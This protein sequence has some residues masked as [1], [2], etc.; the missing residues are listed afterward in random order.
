M[1]SLT[2][3]KDEEKLLKSFFVASI[4]I[5]LSGQV[6][7]A[8]RLGMLSTEDIPKI[9]V[10]VA[11]SLPKLE[12]TGLDVK[13]DLFVTND[14]RLYQGKKTIEFKCAGV[15]ALRKQKGS[16]VLLAAL[17]SE[18]GLLTLGRERYQG[19]LLLLGNPKNESCDVVNEIPME[20]YI[21]PLLAKEMHGGWPVEALKAQAV[22]A[23]SYALD[24]IQSQEASRTVGHNTFYDLESSEKHQVGGTFFDITEN[25]L[26]AARSTKG[27]VL[28]TKT[29]HKLT[30]IFFHSECGGDTFLPDQIWG[31]KIE[32]YQSVACPDEMQRKDNIWKVQIPADTFRKFLN[33]VSE[34]KFKI[35]FDALEDAN[36]EF[37]FAP[38]KL[39]FLKVR[40]YFGENVLVVGKMDFKRFF[41][42]ITFPS[43]HFMLKNE[44]GRVFALGRGLG[45]GVGMS[46]I[47][48][49]YLAEKGW[50]YRQILEYYYP[51]HMIKKI[52]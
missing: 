20:S 25:T 41:G 35:P 31:N 51:G 7:A 48:A 29:T 3:F 30:P 9:R 11:R 40:I 46:Q 1:M 44:N 26:D 39:S 38:D 27:E 43:N 17:S 2:F 34:K 32:G 45:H 33:W 13:R 52:Y 23:R 49:K 42:R 24:K 28:F 50:N 12:V 16:P 21:A 4:S 18:T 22:A 36:Q 8:A 19:R 5:V 37:I 14:V 10:M 15:G 47:G 6:F